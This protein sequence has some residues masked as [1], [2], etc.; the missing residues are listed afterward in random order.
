MRKARDHQSGDA[1]TIKSA[2]RVL[3]ILEYLKVTRQPI[4]TTDLATSFNWPISSTAALLKSLASL[5]Y[6]V[7][8]RPTR[9]YR[10]SVRVGLLGGWSYDDGLDT[11]RINRLL[12]RL[13]VASGVSV[14]VAARN[15]VYCQCVEV[16]TNCAQSRAA[17]GSKRYLSESTLGLTL[18]AT[19]D[20]QAAERILRRINAEQADPQNRLKIARAMERIRAI[21]A[22]GYAFEPGDQPCDTAWMVR[23]VSQ[24]NRQLLA[25]GLAASQQEMM[26]RQPA[27][28]NLLDS[29]VREIC[30]EADYDMLRTA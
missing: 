30:V 10:A 21:R 13:A 15:D 9:T 28:A 23:L 20:D 17:V 25:V 2:R 26:P 8:D 11:V 24:P 1:P 5:G 18:L 19:E 22:R 27:F 12:Q 7:F 16:I 4:S 14:H 6:L 29:T 3:D